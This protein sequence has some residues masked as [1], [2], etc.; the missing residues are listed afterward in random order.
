MKIT[1]IMQ[2]VDV[3]AQ[4]LP[5]IYPAFF[6]I[7]SSIFICNRPKN[8][9]N[10]AKSIV[11]FFFYHVKIFLSLAESHGI[12]I[13]VVGWS[14]AEKKLLFHKSYVMYAM[15]RI[16]FSLIRIRRSVSSN[17]RAESDS[18]SRSADPFREITDLAL[19]PDPD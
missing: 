14:Y 11:Y 13:V 9:G 16:H 3:L 7:A 5:F 17:K 6:F 8:I 4:C 19:D 2:R 18:I 15:L 12:K 10:I 1:K